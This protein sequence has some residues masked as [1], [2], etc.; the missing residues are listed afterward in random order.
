[1]KMGNTAKHPASEQIALFVFVVAALC[2]FALS[3]KAKLAWVFLAPCVASLFWRIQ[4]L[5]PRVVV[6]TRNAAW[7]LLAGIVLLGLFHRAY[8][9][10][11]EDTVKRPL[12]L[13]G[14]G[15]AFFASL[16][17]LGT[18]VWP[19]AETLFPAAL[20][21]F[22]I[23]A[24]NPLAPYLHVLI[25]FAGLAVVA[26]LIMQG[27]KVE[28]SG[29]AALPGRGQ[30]VRLSI[31]LLAVFLIA[32]TII[33]MLPWLQVRVV[34]ATSQLYNPQGNYYSG[35]SLISRLGDLEELQLSQKVVMRV[36]T[37]RPQK[38]RGRVFTQFDG[39]SWRASGFTNKNLMPAPQIVSGGQPDGQGS[40][41]GGDLTQWLDSI[42]GNI[43]ALSAGDTT[44]AP[45][46]GEVRTKI[47]Q[48][49]FNDGL[50]VSPGGKLLAR[51][52][53][54][55]LRVDT[56]EDLSPPPQ[57]SVEIYGVVN[58]PKGDLV[59][60]GASS[61]ELA[62]QCLALP[63]QTDARLKETA[64]R[65]AAGTNSPAERVQ[66]TVNYLQA[67]C[68]YSLKVGK[69]HSQQ[70]VAEFLFEKKQ[71]YC[72][73]FASAAAVLLRLEGVP[74]RYVTGFNI[75]LGNR[76]GNHY[77]VREADAHAWVEAYMPNEGWVQIDPT[78]EA[79]YEA[80]HANLKS[81][82]WATA[83]EWLA[84]EM[85]EISARFG[86]GDWRVTIHW[87]L[88]QIKMF[89]R[90]VWAAG[91]P[92]RL[93][94]LVLVLGVT[95]L[96]AR[97]RRSSSAGHTLKSALQES[98]SAPPEIVELVRRLDKIWAREGFI[99]PASRAPLEHLGGIPAEKISP[100]LRELS[101]KVIECFYRTSFGGAPFV[102][103]ESRELRRSLE[104]VESARTT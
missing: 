84:S 59:Q 63:A 10:L 77:V 83:E 51:V 52:A 89:L 62:A 56:F 38:L 103:A 94:L 41:D 96:W 101:R 69:F 26:Y 47:V 44:K 37:S 68:H 90:S 65:L 11:S 24:F 34:Q 102:P 58:R 54:P 99:R 36:W 46:T 45:E 7:T 5:P 14:F 74:S 93:L 55:S 2:S 23:S 88:E 30:M 80:L 29:H 75:Q 78:P 16:Y 8:P 98:D 67:Q 57:S 4:R 25:L 42:P 18:R 70:P 87:I 39:Q 95:V 27:G 92:F 1:M 48:T 81:G 12:L 31:P 104:Q 100:S 9:L 53:A 61:A 60:E 17:L 15:L 6:W 21:L 73:Y 32:W 91:R 49:V 43:F 72:E 86:Q 13:A 33:R 40:L 79:E 71:G 19:A 50:L 85:A 64:R 22:L 35:F 66:R 28:T 82:W 76:Q 20:G 97:W 3:R